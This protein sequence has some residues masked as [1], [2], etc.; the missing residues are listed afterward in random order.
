[1]SERVV[2]KNSSS[3]GLLLLKWQVVIQVMKGQSFG[4]CFRTRWSV[5]VTSL[6]WQ[7]NAWV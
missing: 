4:C 3:L 7:S 5:Q 1:M 6:K 2:E